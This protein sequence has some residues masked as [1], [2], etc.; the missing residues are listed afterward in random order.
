MESDLNDKAPAC[1]RGAVLRPD[2]RQHREVEEDVVEPGGHEVVHRQLDVRVV[3]LR[4]TRFLIER[5][6]LFVPSLSG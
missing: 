2:A 6:F 1:E 3:V 5:S 4:E